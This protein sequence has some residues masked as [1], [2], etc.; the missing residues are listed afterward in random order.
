MKFTTKFVAMPFALSFVVAACGSPEAHQDGDA[1]VTMTQEAGVDGTNATAG[2][3]MS[4]AQDLSG[5]LAAGEMDR[6]ETV[7]ALEDLDRLVNDSP[8][9]FPQTIRPKLTEDIAS[10]RS[11]F[12][13]QD[14]QGLQEAATSIRNTLSE[15]DTAA[16]DS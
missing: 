3:A 11:A 9:D 16:G 13:A 6:S 12:E 14:A 8:L 2:Q 5:R 10:A 4:E 15:S 7:V 1:E